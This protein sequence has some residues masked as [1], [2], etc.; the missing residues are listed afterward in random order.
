MNNPVSELN[1][2]QVWSM[3]WSQGQRESCLAANSDADQKELQ[4]LW[5]GVLTDIPKRARVL[6]LACG[7]GAVAHVINETR[8]DLSIDAI[9]KSDIKPID[10]QGS[11]Q[12]DT[13]SNLVFHSQID[14]LKLP[15]RFTDYDLI[16]SQFGIEYAGLARVAEQL[17]TRLN[18]GGQL[19]C[20]VHHSEGDL[21]TSTQKKLSEYTILEGYKLLD[22][23]EARIIVT[24][25]DG[26]DKKLHAEQNLER[27]GHNYM[28]LGT[29]TKPISGSLF[30]AIGQILTCAQKNITEAQRLLDA[31]RLKIA[32]EQSR[33][34]Q[35]VSA[36]QDKDQIT[37]F[38]KILESQGFSQCEATPFYV[39]E[40]NSKYLLAWQCHAVFCLLYTSPSPRDRG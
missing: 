37:Q 21:Y 33:L 17:A 25:G 6:D 15:T 1:D 14:I 18:K 9:D 31:L 3:Y 20:L 4:A 22:L 16:C 24:T 35:M 8:P 2:A 36:A 19:L 7:N 40:E 12:S 13:D 11:N 5:R 10:Q 29:G 27:A 23:L 39:G 38:I 30:A 26:E 32:A 34:Q 28:A